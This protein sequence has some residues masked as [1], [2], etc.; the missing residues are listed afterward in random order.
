MHMQIFATRLYGFKELFRILDSLQSYRG[1]AR[2]QN[3]DFESQV[4]GADLKDGVDFKAGLALKTLSKR[5]DFAALYRV[6]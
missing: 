2:L 6:K 5:D 1:A 3:I 4:P